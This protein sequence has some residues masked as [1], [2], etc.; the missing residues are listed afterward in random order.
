MAVGGRDRVVIAPI[1]H[2]GQRADSGSLLLAGFIGSRR[3]RQ[4]GGLV[5]HQ[6][7]ADGL[8]MTTQPVAQPAPAVLQQLGVEF[9]EAGCPWD[10][11]HEVAPRVADQPF[12]L[13]LVVALART[14][15]AVG[16]QVVG[17]QLAE[18]F[19]PQPPAVAQDARHRQ[20]GVVVQ[21]R[22]R[23][24]AEEL[25]A[26]VVPFAEGFATLRRIG[27]H[28]T[29]VAVRQVHRKKMDLLLNSADYSQRFAEVGLR[30]PRIVAQRHE[31][32]AQ[33]QPP[34]VHVVPDDRD[35][36]AIA[37]L[38]PQPL[39]DPLRSMLLFRRLS[40]IFFQDPLND[41]DERVQ[42]WSCRRPA[43]PVP[44][45]HRER[46]HFR[47][48][49]RGDPKSP[50]RFPSADPFY[51][52]R[53]PYL[54]VQLHAFHPSA[55]CPSWQKTFCCRTF[56]PA[57]PDYPAASVRDFLSGALNRDTV[58]DFNL[59]QG[60]FFDTATVHILTTATLQRLHELYPEGRFAVPRFRPN[61][62]VSSPDV[63]SGFVENVWLGRIVAI[64]ESVRLKIDLN[65]ARCVMTTL[66]QRDLPK[67]PGILRTVAQ[68]NQVNVGVY[69]SVLQG[70]KIQRGDSIRLE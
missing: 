27:L 35:P 7:F 68:H 20:L 65:C 25:E 6:P 49:P 3:Q 40:L 38:V 48:R 39:E 61:V 33:P 70:G 54:P 63:S 17:L 60:T 56:A 23:H 34:L 37:V 29:A 30:M 32:L 4:Q 64:G 31:H 1:A 44:R 21:D 62:V 52:N 47:H 36:A 11:H 59:P 13:A 57:Q 46:Q 19:S 45:R 67:D 42:F 14:P 41:P 12:N 5:S 9:R 53:S 69:A 18:D 22:A 2:Q 15:E 24:P 51:I 50:R 66:A 16:E 10:R 26:D 58:T 28:Q 43:P 55:L 8:I